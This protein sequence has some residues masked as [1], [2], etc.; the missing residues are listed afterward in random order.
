MVILI[1]GPVNVG[2]IAS[3]DLTVNSIVS[4]LHNESLDSHTAF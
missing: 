1:S 3:D 2:F 4:L